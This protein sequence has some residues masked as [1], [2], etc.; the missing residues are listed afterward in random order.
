MGYPAEAELTA[1]LRTMAKEAGQYDIDFVTQKIENAGAATARA[2]EKAKV[3]AERKKRIK[4]ASKQGSA[5][6]SVK[7]GGCRTI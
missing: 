2:K 6:Y 7:S 3:D 1:I 4:A 5:S